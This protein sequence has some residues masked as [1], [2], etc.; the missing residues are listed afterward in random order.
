MPTSFASCSNCSTTFATTATS[1][2]TRTLPRFQR[3]RT[4]RQMTSPRTPRC[5]DKHHGYTRRD[6]CA[7]LLCSSSFLRI[8]RPIRSA[9][10]VAAR[11]AGVS[12][13]CGPRS[14]RRSSP[15]PRSRTC[16]K[17]RW[18]CGTSTRSCSSRRSGVEQDSNSIVNHSTPLHLLAGSADCCWMDLETSHSS[19]FRRRTGA[20]HLTDPRVIASVLAIGLLR[21]ALHVRV[22]GRKRGHHARF[23]RERL[24]PEVRVGD[25]V[26]SL[27][28]QIGS[29]T[30][31]RLHPPR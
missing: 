20:E 25:R 10:S 5:A 31:E 15:L 4:L 23:L 6:A 21:L 17:R 28:S 3:R 11:V 7:Q 16:C 1:P 26:A 18:C 30:G 29:V 2:S 22:E 12:A 8:D 13:A 24:L 27:K 14:R 9:E 19:P